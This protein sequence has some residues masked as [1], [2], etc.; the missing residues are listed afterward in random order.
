MAILNNLYPPIVETYAP[1]FL[2]DSGNTSKDT[3]RVYFSIS[4]YNSRSDIKNAQVTVSNQNTNRSMLDETKYPCNIMLTPVY[5]DRTKSSADKYY[6]EIK[7]DDMKDGQFEIN[8]YYK[9]QIRFTSTKAMNP[10][11][12]Y[13]TPQAIDSWLAANSSLFSEWSTVC[14]IRGIS[15]PNLT[16]PGFDTAVDYTIW[17]VV[18]VNIDGTLVFTNSEETD[19]LKSY[20]IKLYDDKDN[21]LVDTNTLYSNNYSG[22]NE[23]NYMFKYAFQDGETYHITIDYTTRNLYSD[24]RSYTFIV[25][26]GLLDALNADIFS[27]EDEENGR[28]AVRVKNKTE[29][30]FTGN[31]IIRRA[32]GETNFTIWED[33]GVIVLENDFLDYTWYDYTIKSGV[34]YKYCIQRCDSS[35]NRGIATELETP[36]MVTFEHMFLTAGGKQLNIKFNPQ[37]SSFKYTVSETKT[38]TLGSKYPFVKRNGNTFY[39]QFSINGLVSHFIDEDHLLT[40]EEELYG[41]ILSWYE[42]YNDENYINEYNDVT[43]ERD[44]REVVMDFLYKNNVKLFRSPTEG[45]ILVKITDISFT[46]EETLGRM[47]YSFSCN[48]YEIAEFTP[49]N[50]NTY[51]IQPIQE[52][53]THL[54][55]Q[56]S[57]IGQLQ[58]TVPAGTDVLDLL[59]EKYSKMSQKGYVCQVQYLDYLKI[60][61]EQEPYLIKENAAGPYVVDDTASNGDTDLTSAYLGYISYING[62]SIVINKEGI[63]EL[64]GDDVQITSLTFPV[65]T[66]VNISYT[67]LTSQ[68]EDSTQAPDVVEYYKK[69]GQY[70]G[71]FDYN[72]SIFQLIWNKYYENYSTYIQSLLS[73]DSIKIEADPGT[74]VYVAESGEKAVSRFVINDTGLLSFND[75]ETSITGIYFAGVHFEEATEDEQ[76]RD[77]MPENKYINTGIT[78]TSLEDIENPVKNG[79]YTLDTTD[80]TTKAKITNTQNDAYDNLVTKTTDTQYASTL[81]DN[82]SAGQ[83]IWYNDKWWLFTD[84]HDLLC[85]VEALI[86][87]CYELYKGWYTV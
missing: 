72:D 28:I 57:Y 34:W 64:Q 44:F 10:S 19:T 46:P 71:A 5:E 23:I 47:L 85:S 84:S 68:D 70:W 37:I 18:N 51:G 39:R 36:V 4:L 80:T 67:I 50:C 21:L 86:D 7:K 66:T 65:D 12:G 30:R 78:V 11:T 75:D 54:V 43:Y 77:L 73:I 87:Y 9:V 49:D 2:L 24:S 82:L 1:A 61:M 76:A 42:T 15:T 79:V 14:L 63:Y 74:V 32:S 6:I 48:A 53:A 22:I 33:V 17:S 69:V 38:D 55:Y 81:E 3:C 56:E 27:E 62:E 52:L 25:I 59:Q 26:L 8:Q 58:E 83:Y 40:S 45:N 16:I 41:D 20:R 35:G 31:I 60:E 29:E 13:K